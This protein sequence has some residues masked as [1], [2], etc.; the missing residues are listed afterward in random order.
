MKGNKKVRHKEGSQTSNEDKNR[1]INKKLKNMK[2][3]CK[4]REEKKRTRKMKAA[5]LSNTAALQSESIM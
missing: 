5:I 4:K 2:K 1:R 3:I